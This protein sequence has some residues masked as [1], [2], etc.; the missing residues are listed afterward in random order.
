VK[1]N[2]EGE[3]LKINK[4]Q[5]ENA[6]KFHGHECPGIWIGI[7]AAE[8]CLSET[9]ANSA[10][11]PVV[12][13]T[14]TDNC[15]VDAIQTLTGCTF[16]KG[17]LIHRDYGKNAFSFFNR[18]TLKGFRAL[19]RP[20]VFK[21]KENEY[22]KLSDKMKSKKAS[23]HE[24]KEFDALKK[25]RAGEVRE[26]KVEE[27][28]IISRAETAAPKQP[29][30]LKSKKCKN[31]GEMTME[32]RLRLLGGEVFCIPCFGKLEQKT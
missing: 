20:G 9:G 28:F 23:E 10:E 32:S 15:A 25:K 12:C 14:E 22:K 24:K 8:L 7:R 11:N 1:K 26:L 19:V 13:V 4:K 29:Y 27:L 2:T 30:I 17:N 16:G 31:C 3:T 6:I 5:I 21:E 18:N